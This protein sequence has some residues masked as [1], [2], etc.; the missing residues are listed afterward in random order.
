M[1]AAVRAALGHALP[2]A[3]TS[4][5]DPALFTA[6]WAAAVAAPR[7]ADIHV[8]CAVSVGRIVGFTAVAPTVRVPDAALSSGA[9]STRDQ[10][11]TQQLPSPG[12]SDA[13]APSR[14]GAP[15]ADEGADVVAAPPS[16]RVVYEFTALE[17]AASDQ[18]QGHGSR[19]LA[20][21]TDI[22]RGRGATE[23]QLWVL[24]GDDAHTSFLASAGFAPSGLRRSL[25]IGGSIA[26]QHCWHAEL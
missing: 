24:A 2:A 9:T 4:R 16:G 17:V 7:E 21:A 3:V 5:F 8:L 14:D 18:R 19:L 15:S 12:V 10:A 6:Q 11:D 26:I 13:S 1:H 25:D 20:A 23:A 22:A